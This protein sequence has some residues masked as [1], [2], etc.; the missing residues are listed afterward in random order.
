MADH[1]MGVVHGAVSYMPEMVQYLSTMHP[2][3]SVKA[4]E[5]KFSQ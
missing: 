5:S 1:V 2:D 3:L 4:G